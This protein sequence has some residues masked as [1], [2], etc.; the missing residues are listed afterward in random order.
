MMK[1][2]D[3]RWCNLIQVAIY[4]REVIAAARAVDCDFQPCRLV[5]IDRHYTEE[6]Q[7]KH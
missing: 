4:L 5:K 3:L 2:L 7:E 1:C 6:A